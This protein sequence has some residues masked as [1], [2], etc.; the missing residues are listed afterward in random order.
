M[1]VSI[2]YSVCLTGI[3]HETE[4][5]V[6]IEET[7]A[8]TLTTEEYL[9]A[10]TLQTALRSV[11]VADVEIDIEPYASQT[12]LEMLAKTIYGEGRGSDICEQAAIVWCILNRVD[13]YE[14]S[15][16]EIITAENQFMGYKDYFPVE[17]ELY[18]LAVDVLTRYAREKN[19]ATDVGRV[20]PTEYL[21]FSGD[22]THNYFRDA[23]SGGNYWDFSYENPY[24]IG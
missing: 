3:A 17:P 23:Y 11:S 19:G 12:E 13:T 8:V 9:H 15:I 10:C 20:L 5:D 21:W 16:E 4:A 18:D 22:L 2:S 1:V 6:I 7:P 14:Q 24:I